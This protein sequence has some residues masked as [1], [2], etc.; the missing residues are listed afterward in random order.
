MVRVRYTGWPIKEL[1]LRLIA[2]IFK[3]SRMICMIS[4][5]FLAYF[6]E[7]YIPNTD[8]VEFIAN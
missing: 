2:G 4:V 8:S 5:I 1:Q 6:Q 3:T 7:R